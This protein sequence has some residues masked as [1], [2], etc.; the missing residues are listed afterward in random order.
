MVDLRVLGH[1]QRHRARPSASR[2]LHIVFFLTLMALS[3]LVILSDHEAEGTFGPETIIALQIG[4]IGV[5][6]ATCEAT[7]SCPHVWRQ[8]VLYAKPC[9]LHDNSA[10]SKPQYQN[11]IAQVRREALILSEPSRRTIAYPCT[12][13]STR[14][15]CFFSTKNTARHTSPVTRLTLG[16]SRE[17]QSKVY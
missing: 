7:C 11:S 3:P 15:P 14:V 1:S 9:A 10:T 6:P 17:S 13:L 4:E 2:A 8:Q 5:I 12:S 16:E